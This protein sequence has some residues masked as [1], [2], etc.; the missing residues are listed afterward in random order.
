MLI[1]PVVMNVPIN[2]VLVIV[3]KSVNLVEKSA[4]EGASVDLI[5]LE[6]IRKNNPIYG[7]GEDLLRK[8]D[9]L[10]VV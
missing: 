3:L 7:V 4:I 8:K 6:V 10:V 2:G 1:K 9:L 5:Y